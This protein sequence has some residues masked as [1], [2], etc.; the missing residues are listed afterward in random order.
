MSQVN[1]IMSRVGHQLLNVITKG[2]V[3][4]QSKD[5]SHEEIREAYRGIKNSIDEMDILDLDNRSYE[6]LLY[7][8]FHK[9]DN[10][11]NILLV[12]IWAF[13]LLADGTELTSISGKSV[14]KGQDSIDLDVRFGCIS[15]GIDISGRKPDLKYYEAH[16]PYYA[17]IKATDTDEALEVYNKVVA[18]GEDIEFT[19]VSTNYALA[20]FSRVP[21]EDTNSVPLK[22][23]LEDF[24]SEDSTILIIDGSLI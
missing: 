8:G 23:I 3:S 6:E 1:R 4:N 18:D 15:Y 14:I 2:E 24:E 12:P 11:S 5:Y 19:E 16:D 21:G 9:W 13:D 22:D 17:L 7:L 20:K 10:E